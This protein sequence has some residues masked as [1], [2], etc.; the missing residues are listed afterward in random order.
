MELAPG[1]LPLTAQG[2]ALG[3]GRELA[4]EAPEAAAA[5][6]AEVAVVLAPAL[7]L[8][9]E[10]AQAMAEQVPTRATRATTPVAGMRTWTPT[11]TACMGHQAQM[12]TRTLHEYGVSPCDA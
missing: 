5:A 1:H 6:A 2:L 9:L 3:L 7:A 11:S 4:P 10:L 12:M 8:A